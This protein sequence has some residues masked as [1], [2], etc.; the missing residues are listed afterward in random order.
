M[1][2]NGI[3]SCKGDDVMRIKENQNDNIISDRN[4]RDKCV[5]N[6]AEQKGKVLFRNSSYR[7][8]QAIIQE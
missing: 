4:I 5:I 8:G 1:Y 3:H 2:S 6:T 7:E